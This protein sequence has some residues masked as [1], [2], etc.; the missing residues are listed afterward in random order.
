MI[1]DFWIITGSYLAIFIATIFLLN[2]FTKGFIWTWLRVLLSR[3]KLILVQVRN[4]IQNY[5][6]TGKLESDRVVVRD[7]ESKAEKGKKSLMLQENVVYRSFGV[8]VVYYD[9]ATNELLKPN[10]EN[11]AGADLLKIDSLMTRCL[12]KPQSEEDKVFRRNVYIA[13]VVIIIGVALIYFKVG[14]I[15]KLVATPAVVGGVLNGFVGFRVRK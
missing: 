4:P 12:F 8:N 6:I 3:G 11:V 5:W 9:E 15:A 10:L 14:E 7:N 1:S 2:F 13:L